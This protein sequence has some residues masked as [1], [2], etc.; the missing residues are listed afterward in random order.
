MRRTI[1]KPTNHRR[2]VTLHGETPVIAAA[3]VLISSAAL[4]QS[5][6]EKTGINAPAPLAWRSL[7]R[8]GRMQRRCRSSG[9]F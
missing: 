3:A 9:S 6:T 5:T 2:E 8:I 7:V 4:A 1:E